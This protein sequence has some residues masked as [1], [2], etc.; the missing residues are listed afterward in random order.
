MEEAE[1]LRKYMPN[2]ETISYKYPQ[3]TFKQSSTSVK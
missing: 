2:F 3:Y 1:D